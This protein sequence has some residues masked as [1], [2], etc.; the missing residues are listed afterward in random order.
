MAKAKQTVLV[1]D[2]D[3]QNRKVLAERLASA[4]FAVEQAG[5]GISALQLVRERDIRLVVSEL[6]LKTGE[7]DCLIQAVRQHR[8]RGTRTL[9]HTVHRKAADLAWAKQWGASGFLIQPT[10]SE[11]LQRAVT[12]LLGTG[13]SARSATQSRRDT[14]DGALAEIERGDLP[15]TS[16]IVLSRSWWSDLSSTERNGFRMRA[17][18]VRVSLRSDSMMSRSFVELRA[19]PRIKV[20]RTARKA[21]ASPYRQSQ[22]P[23]KS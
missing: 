1:V 20:A 21:G 12:Q 23:A 22:A 4:G 2:P 15:H 13:P 9:A 17:K 18:R 7:S 11:R 10:A 5:D 6:Y 19:G 16:S 8:L 3:S 14:L